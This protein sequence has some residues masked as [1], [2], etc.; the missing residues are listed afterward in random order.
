MPADKKLAFPDQKS[1]TSALYRISGLVDA[2]FAISETNAAEQIADGAM[3]GVQSALK[4]EVEDL[5]EAAE[6]GEIIVNSSKGE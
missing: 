1:L 6:A 2:V 5:L 4:R 3:D